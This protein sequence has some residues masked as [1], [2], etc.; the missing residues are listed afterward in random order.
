MTPTDAHMVVITAGSAAVLCS[1]V[2]VFHLVKTKPIM[3]EPGEIEEESDF[4]STVQTNI[5]GNSPQ[6]AVTTTSTST[7][8]S[9]NH[10]ATKPNNETKLNIWH[11]LKSTLFHVF[12]IQRP[13]NQPHSR[14]TSLPHF[15]HSS[16]QRTISWAWNEKQKGKIAEPDVESSII[17]IN[18]VELRAFWRTGRGLR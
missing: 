17:S 15:L 11:L 3:E 4:Q 1:A 10:T 18:T 7:A 9:F 16:S 2:A 6:H 14:S 12:H 13:P 8:A 5:N